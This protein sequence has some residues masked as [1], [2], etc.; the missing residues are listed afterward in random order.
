VTSDAQL[1][2]DGKWTDGESAAELT[3]KFDGSRV[4]DLHIPSRAQVAEAVGS[5]AAE[6]QAHPL[7]PYDRFRILSRTAELLDAE[8]D[9]FAE[10]Y[11]LDSGLTIVDARREIERAV[12]T[13]LLCGEEAKRLT[14][15]MVPFSSTPAGGKRLGFTVRHPIGVVVA[16]TPFNSPVNTPAHKIG[17]AL[18]AGNGVVFKPAEKT[19]LTANRLVELLLEAGLP[20]RLIAVVHGPGSTVGQWLLEDERPGFYA[21]T[22]S[23]AVGTHIHSTVGV[24]PT[25]MELGGLSSTII[26]DDAALERAASLCVNAGFRKSGQVCTSVQRLYVQRSVQDEFAERLLALLSER[27][28]GDP[29]AE[30]TF[31]GPLIS[32]QAADR[33]ESWVNAATAQGARLLAGGT[34]DRQVIEPTLLADVTG[35]MDVMCREIFGPV[36]SLRPFD[37]LQEAIDEANNTPYGLAAGIFTAS[38][39]RALQAADQLHVGTVHINESSSARID[40]M[41]YGGV[42]RS[43]F[44]KEGPHYAIREMT[45]ERLITLGGTD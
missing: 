7:S 27:H 42:K 29:R 28:A 3:N 20:E 33:V 9:A 25:Q 37:Q 41:P 26:C 5:V 40:L 4:G 32:P 35:D 11:V 22:G 36:V 16:I 45:E 15:D 38:L 19:P 17:P 6:Q 14:G 1:L 18:A 44:G 30:D 24:R 10:L 34:R 13:M 31:I 23:T 12:Q 39:D 43:G 8:R 2:I 21:F